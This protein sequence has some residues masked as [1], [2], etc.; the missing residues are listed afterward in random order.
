MPYFQQG[1]LSIQFL[2]CIF[3]LIIKIN[4]TL[5]AKQLS[6]TYFR[7]RLFGYRRNRVKKDSME[8]EN[9]GN[10]QNV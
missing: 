10:L 2:I 3:V 8:E 9:A 1:E 4:L 7:R 6:A 5:L